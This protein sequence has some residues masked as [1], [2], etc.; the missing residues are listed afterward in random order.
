LPNVDRRV[1]K[2]PAGGAGRALP[3]RVTPKP[4]ALVRVMVGR[5]D[6]LTPERERDVERL[7]KE[8]KGPSAA[9]QASAAREL[10]K[11][12]RFAAPAQKKAEERLAR[13]R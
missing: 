2:Q 7:V 12:G 1:T 13:R 8:S 6:V 10:A 4:D 3:L 11:L 5:H 9:A